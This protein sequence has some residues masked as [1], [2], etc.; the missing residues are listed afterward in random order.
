R[1]FAE[2][3]DP[4][5]D[6]SRLYAIEPSLTVTGAAAD[7]R[8]ARRACEIE[9]LLGALLARLVLDL[10][11]RP[12]GLP[13]E[14][15]PLLAKLRDSRDGRFLDA[16]AR[17]LARAHGR[18]LVVAG[19]RQGE[20]AHALALLADLALGAI[21]GPLAITQPILLGADEPRAGLADLVEAIAAG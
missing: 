5:H 9:P 21:G 15:D 10:G 14:L 13:R 7:H 12:P 8:L 1:D 6:M 2:R 4:S 19:A 17:D 11:L 3:R 16:L 20:T 18:A